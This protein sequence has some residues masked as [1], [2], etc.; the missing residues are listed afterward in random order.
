[1]CLSKKTDKV[2]PL[3][4]PHP[5]HHPGSPPKPSSILNQASP[6]QDPCAPRRPIGNP[7]SNPIGKPIGISW[8]CLLRYLVKSGV[9]GAPW[10]LMTKLTFLIYFKHM[11]LFRGLGGSWDPPGWILGQHIKVSKM[12]YVLETK[13][14]KYAIDLRFM[15]RFHFE[16]RKTLASVY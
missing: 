15:L 6:A 14:C 12:W 7:I 11:N 5:T 3:S 16:S 4:P 10:E 2:C 8:L 9:A 1:M 13:R